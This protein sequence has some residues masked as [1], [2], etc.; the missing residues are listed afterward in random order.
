MH[1][2]TTSTSK[3]QEQQVD[4]HL[5]ALERRLVREH[6]HVPAAVL[7]EWIH[8]IRARFTGARVHAFVPI[9]VERRVRARL[10]AARAGHYP[11]GSEPPSHVAVPE[12][13]SYRDQM[14][15]RTWAWFTAKR[16]LSDDLPRRWAHTRAVAQRAEEVAPALPPED[17]QPLVAAAWLHDIGY[18]PDLVDTGLHSLDGARFL[19]AEHIPQRICAVVAHHSGAAAVAQVRGLTDA[20]NAYPD[21]HGPTR[22]ALWY[23]DMTTSP[24]GHPVSVEDRLAEIRDRRGPHDPSVRAL[25]LNEA[26]RVAAVR[27]TE[28]LL[29]G[30]T[31]PATSGL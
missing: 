20:L 24:H 13:R 10:R 16:L 5:H 30:H 14:S 17:R 23:C 6:E 1:T 2:G 19:T 8:D 27:R 9:L 3:E 22:D 28:Q 21:E 4:Q 11:I 29:A 7:H 25:S 31:A 18:A 12:P 26:E 15:L